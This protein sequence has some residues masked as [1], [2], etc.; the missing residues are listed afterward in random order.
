MCSIN[1][2]LLFGSY[3]W[4][5]Y[6]TRINVYMLTPSSQL[7]LPVSGSW[8]LCREEEILQVHSGGACHVFPPPSAPGFS[9]LRMQADLAPGMWLQ[10]RS[11]LPAG[12]R[13]GIF[14]RLFVFNLLFELEYIGELKFCWFGF[15]FFFF[16]LFN[17]L[18]LVHFHIDVYVFFLGGGSF[19]IQ[20]ITL[21]LCKI[22]RV[23]QWV[24]ESYFRYGCVHML[25]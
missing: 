5:I 19:Y 21:V 15:F 13:V 9:S 2:P 7:L 16:L 1:F 3:F 25:V 11:P 22:P 14:P 18:H 6:P 12:N 8:G 20:V 23:T 17:V 10:P 4:I 24:L